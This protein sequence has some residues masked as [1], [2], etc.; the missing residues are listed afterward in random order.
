[1]KPHVAAIGQFQGHL[2]RPPDR[3]QTSAK[4]QKKCGH[5]WQRL[6]A[7]ARAGN[8]KRRHFEYLLIS[9]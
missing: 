7:M 3:D 4:M 1:M 8:S 6:G 5:R 9:V 2:R